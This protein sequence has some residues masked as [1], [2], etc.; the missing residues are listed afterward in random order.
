MPRS[1]HRY[2]RHLA[3]NVTLQ[4]LSLSLCKLTFQ[5]FLDNPSVSAECVCAR[6]SFT[7]IP[8][9][10]LTLT[11]CPD[12]V[13]ESPMS[14]GLTWVGIARPGNSLRLYLNLLLEHAF[15]VSPFPGER[16]T[17]RVA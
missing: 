12:G 17:G 1:L 10:G 16:G 9:W 4:T 2:L 6:Q 13:E 7:F 11:A 3:S 5:I 8:S 15:P 14:I